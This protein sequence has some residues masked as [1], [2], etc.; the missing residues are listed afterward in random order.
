MSRRTIHPARIL[1]PKDARERSASFLDYQKSQLLAIFT[2]CPLLT[3]VWLIEIDE[4]RAG[5]E[6]KS[7]E[8]KT[9]GSQLIRLS[10]FK[11]LRHSDTFGSG[12]IGS[13][14]LV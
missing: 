7:R 12:G 5:M 4:A 9:N 13:S 11:R 14:G 2:Q 8:L 10:V 1:H 6:E 3:G